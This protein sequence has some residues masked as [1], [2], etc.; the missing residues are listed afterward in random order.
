L[1]LDDVRWIDL[2]GVGMGVEDLIVLSQLMQT[3][4]TATAVDLSFNK[5]TQSSTLGAGKE[6]PRTVCMWPDLPC[7]RGPGRRLCGVCLAWR[8][9]CASCP[10][11]RVPSGF[12]VVF[13]K[14]NRSSFTFTSTFTFTPRLEQDLQG[15]RAFAEA[16]R[17]NTRLEMIDLQVGPCGYGFPFFDV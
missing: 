11:L 14:P 5:L 2:C 9:S 12:L 7:V 17:K 16:L 3:N 13:E 10:Q 8:S 15:V 1:Q 4:N 6:V